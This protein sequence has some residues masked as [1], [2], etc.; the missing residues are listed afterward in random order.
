MDVLSPF[1]GNGVG[2][3]VSVYQ[4]LHL[5]DESNVW[6]I[7]GIW[8]RFAQMKFTVSKNTFHHYIMPLD[9]DYFVWPLKSNSLCGLFE[10]QSFFNFS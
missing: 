1:L 8:K 2:G 7:V 10:G 4:S 3:Q 5:T 9:M 6:H